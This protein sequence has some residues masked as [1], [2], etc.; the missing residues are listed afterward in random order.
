M[1]YYTSTT[2]FNCG[3]DLHSRQMYVCVMDPSYVY[4]GTKRPV[5]ALLRQRLSYVW[6]RA[7]LLARIECHQLAEGKTLTP[8]NFS[9]HFQRILVKPD[10]KVE[11]RLTWPA[12]DPH[13]S[14]LVQPIHGGTVDGVI[15][16]RFSL[17]DSKAI[18]FVF[19]NSGSPGE[20]TVRLR[21]GTTEEALEFWVPTTFAKNEPYAIH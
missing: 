7:E 13:D 21:R 17:R 3:I 15:S 10:E 5:R 2:E 12:N 1:K 19:Q 6:R 4:P 11:V 9:G 18:R 16:K 8:A 20:Y 14:V